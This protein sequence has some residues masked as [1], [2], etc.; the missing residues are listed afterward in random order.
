MD[1][2]IENTNTQENELATD[3]IEEIVISDSEPDTE[4]T[5]SNY[6]F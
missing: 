1:E 4:T 3:I 6:T 5:C 2:K